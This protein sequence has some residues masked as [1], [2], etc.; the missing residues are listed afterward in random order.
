MHM[1]TPVGNGFILNSNDKLKCY[2]YRLLVGYGYIFTSSG[3]E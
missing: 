3:A 1:L 2:D